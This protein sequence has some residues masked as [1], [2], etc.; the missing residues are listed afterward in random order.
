MLSETALR[1]LATRT[2]RGDAERQ[3]NIL[4]LGGIY[5]EDEYPFCDEVPP[6]ERTVPEDDYPQV[7]SMFGLRV[8][9][10]KGEQ[11]SK[12]QRDLWDAVQTKAP[13]WALFHRLVI[14]EDDMK[15]QDFGTQL[16]DEFEAAIWQ[17]ADE[18][19]LEP[20]ENGGRR[21]SATFDLTK[22]QKEDEDN[23]DEPND[24]TSIH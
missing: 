10:W 21:V 5:W 20:D 14:S 22:E 16:A 7:L 4:P 18:I 3:I 6:W 1:Y 13:T 8:R 9:L 23:A 2:F 15:A 24:D 19:V 12:E 11:F 17:D